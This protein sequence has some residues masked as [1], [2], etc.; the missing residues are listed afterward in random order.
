MAAEADDSFFLHPLQ[1]D[2]T[3]KAIS[4]PTSSQGSSLAAELDSLNTLHRALL[5]LDSP[6]V[7]PPPRPVNPKRSAQVSKLRDSANTAYRKSTIPEAIRLYTY[8]I[9][10]AL[11]RPPWEPLGL[12]REELAP[13]YANRAQAHMSQQE[14]AEGWIDAQLSI[15]CND[16]TNTKAWWRGGK[17]LVE[18][19]RW[20][21]AV[22]WLQRG[23]EAEGIETDGGRELKTLMDDAQKGLARA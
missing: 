21:E 2:P 13:L 5:N 6:N 23:L 8:A 15:E 22:E 7:P 3:S 9:D 18:M 10:M 17:C 1:L 12:V 20:E 16:E 11:G 19:G 4:A 14:W